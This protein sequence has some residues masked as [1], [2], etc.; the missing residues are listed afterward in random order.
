MRLSQLFGK[1]VREA[2]AEA[3]TASH[4]LLIRAG[5]INQVAAG[6]YTYMPLAFRVL[7]KIEYI[8]RDEMNKAG[9]QELLMP[10]LQPLDIWKESGRDEALGPVLFHLKD[11]R[12]RDLVLAPTHEEV[13]TMLA[14]R[15][16]QSYRDLPVT[17]YQIQTK[18]RDEAR[19]RAGLVRVREFI[20]K[21]AYSF[22]F[23]EEGLDK[24][25]CPS[26]R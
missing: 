11:R 2:P 20:M 21:D 24:S 5:M 13:I 1:T 8:I 12:E 18:F 3:E 6:I 4:Q 7:K 23:S 22:D 17:L 25:Y 14:A 16:I 19:P 26:H 10:S 9:G 15:N